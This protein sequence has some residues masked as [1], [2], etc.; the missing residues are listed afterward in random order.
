[1]KFGLAL[2]AALCVV[3]CSPSGGD[4]SSSSTTPTTETKTPAG[5]KPL[6]AF[7]QANSQDPWRKVFD[8]ETKAEADK[9]S[10]DFSF[11]E[12]DAGG[13][14]EK[15]NNV[16][17]TFMVKTP[18]VLLVSPNDES[19]GKS[20]DKAFDA[21][22]K[23]IL[24]DRSIPGDKY[25]AWI[26]GDNHE[27][28]REAGE[29]VAKRLNGKGTVLMIQGIAQATPTKDRAGGFMEVMAKNPGIKV[30]MGDDCGY[31]RQKARSY[32]ETFLQKD[33]AIDCVYAHN[34]EMAIGAPSRGTL[35]ARPPKPRCSSAST[36]VNRK[37]ST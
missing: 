6:V 9:H 27:I 24:L 37:W 3:G 5:D 17:D 2:L 29:Y 8:A 20:I 36:A 32:M 35:R 15:Q 34:D 16:I 1:M 21:G 25:T 26:G 14:S 18:K 19:V 33:Q 23:V 11:E 10:A 12:Q 7:S 4:S 13:N 28:G 30:I 31:Q 22:T